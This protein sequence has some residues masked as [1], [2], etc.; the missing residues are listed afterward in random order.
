MIVLPRFREEQQGPLNKLR[1]APLNAWTGSSG[2]DFIVFAAATATPIQVHA[3]A[4][5]AVMPHPPCDAVSQVDGLTESTSTTAENPRCGIVYGSFPLVKHLLYDFPSG[6]A[7][8]CDSPSA[9][10]PSRV[11]RAES[12]KNCAVIFLLLSP[13]T[14]G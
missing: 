5:S 6:A 13:R 10:G 4:E 8:K 9:R 12:S 7:I 11:D 2:I 1:F 3:S 14:R